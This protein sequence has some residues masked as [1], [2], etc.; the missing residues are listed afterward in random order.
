MSCEREG[1]QTAGGRHDD[2]RVPQ[3]KSRHTS[4]TIGRFWSENSRKGPGFPENGAPAAEVLNT[5]QPDV[6]TAVKPGED[7][8][9]VHRDLAGLVSARLAAGPVRQ[10]QRRGGPGR[11]E[12]YRTHGSHRTYS[13]YS[14]YRKYSL[15]WPVTLSSRLARLAIGPETHFMNHEMLA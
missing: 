9:K 14:P 3:P 11:R 4:N 5:I 13:T 10:L 8:F 15:D 1:R 12:P 7:W 6:R 2:D